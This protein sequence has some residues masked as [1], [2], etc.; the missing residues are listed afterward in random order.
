MAQP[1]LASVGD[2]VLRPVTAGDQLLL[3]RIYAS[4]RDEEM[5]ATGWSAR[6]KTTFLE[7]QFQ[8]QQRH[9]SQQ[10]PHAHYR[11]LE[12]QGQ[13]IGRLYWQWNPG[14]LHLIDIALLAPWRGQGLG[15]KVVVELQAL[16]AR[17]QSAV[18]LHVEVGNRAISLYERL[19]FVVTG[20]AG[21]HHRM[22]WSRPRPETGDAVAPPD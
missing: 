13:P 5:A 20:H 4:S 19:G 11:V 6:R 9:F 2:I 17:E 3:R 1:D 18:S 10:H 14:E 8:A 12:R 22:R 15:T 16:A 21:L 7:S